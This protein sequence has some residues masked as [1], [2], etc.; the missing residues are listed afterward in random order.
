MGLIRETL[1]GRPWLAALPVDV[2]A[3]ALRAARTPR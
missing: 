1:L 3:G 2:E